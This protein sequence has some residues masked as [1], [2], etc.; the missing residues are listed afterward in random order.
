MTQSVFRS[1]EKR[2]SFRNYYNTILGN[3]PFGQQYVETA[4]GTTFMLAAGRES[5]P[6]IILLHGSCSNSA[7]WF[8]EM[9]ALSENYRVYAVDIPGEA[10]NSSDVRP[11][12]YSDD[13]AEWIKE[14]LEHLGID[15]AAFIGNSLGGWMAL[16]FATVFPKRVTRLALIAAA[17]IARIRLQFLSHT[18]QARREG[19]TTPLAPS[20][21]GEQ[22][23]P[24]PVLDF[25]NLIIESYNPIEELPL[26]TDDQIFRLDMPVMF[27]GGE[28]D[29]IIDVAESAKRLT[30]LVPSAETHV[31]P[32][33]GH[34]VL[35]ALPFIIPF[36][37]KEM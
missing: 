27:M 29:V 18:A 2:K 26:Y 8:Q 17:G 32:D 24:K 25:I 36:L 15:G 6:P 13:F 20:I 3:L 35:N 22:S 1:P 7:C 5:D 10:G 4:F 12:L 14:V 19:G 21:L 33:C 11:D 37:R 23:L 31:L 16:K 28:E 9:G 30:A 34:A